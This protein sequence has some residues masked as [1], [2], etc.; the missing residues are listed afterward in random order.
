ML[1]IR[2]NATEDTKLDKNGIFMYHLTKQNEQNIN[3]IHCAVSGQT[4]L[5]IIKIYI[6]HA[7]KS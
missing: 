2:L 1:D 5:E 6:V 4:F 7:K 3:Y